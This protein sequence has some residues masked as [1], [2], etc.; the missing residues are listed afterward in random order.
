MEFALNRLNTADDSYEK[1]RRSSLML[2]LLFIGLGGAI[3][4]MCRY[5]VSSIDARWSNGIFPLSTLLINV[6]GSLVIGLLWGFFERSVISPHVRM[7]IF[8]GI[9]GGFT[10]FSTFSLETFHLIR[11]GEI[12][13][14]LMNVA[15]TNIVGIALVFV[16]FW[17]S[18][19]VMAAIK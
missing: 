7:F 16:G 17:L 19:Y 9:L 15:M 6:A 18:R 11:D 14:A 2:R 13:V 12:K 5:L 10:T 3:G 1:E 4:T 8:V